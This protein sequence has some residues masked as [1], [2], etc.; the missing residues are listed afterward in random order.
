MEKLFDLNDDSSS[1]AGG[2]TEYIVA[3]FLKAF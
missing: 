3:A 2:A 1:S